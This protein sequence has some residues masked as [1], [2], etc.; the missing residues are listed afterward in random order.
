M[1]PMKT[2]NRA[3]SKVGKKRANPGIEPKSST[4]VTG[5]TRKLNSHDSHERLA[6]YSVN[7]TLSWGCPKSL[8]GRGFQL[9]E[10]KTS[11]MRQSSCPDIDVSGPSLLV[12]SREWHI[13][14][15]R[16]GPVPKNLDSWC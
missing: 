10:S 1:I 2:F 7:S 9:P 11:K 16:S 3:V 15:T 13:S 8:H 6:V 5:K 4:H 14:R 12:H